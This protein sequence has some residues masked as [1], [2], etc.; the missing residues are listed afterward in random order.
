M[1][2]IKS[3]KLNKTAL[4]MTI[5][6]EEL[7]NFLQQCIQDPTLL[8]DR[9]WNVFKSEGKLYSNDKALNHRLKKIT[10]LY[11]IFSMLKLVIH[12]PLH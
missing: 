9:N 11:M 12:S 6:Y 4:D 3:T 5:H 10:N 7:L 8:L 1:V 2:L